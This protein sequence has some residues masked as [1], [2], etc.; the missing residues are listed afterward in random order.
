M[1]APEWHL[2]CEIDAGRTMKIAAAPGVAAPYRLPV[3]MACTIVALAANAL[4]GKDMPPDTLSYHLYAGFNAVH[5]R[6][7]QDYFPAGPNS[8]FNPYIYAP[9]YYLASSR[10]SSLEISSALAIVHSV[11]LWLTYE[12]ADAVCSSDDRHQRLIFGLCG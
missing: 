2:L 7:A 6:F 1:R 3:Y 12:L 8:Y 9:L 4:L 10:L 5:D 11:M